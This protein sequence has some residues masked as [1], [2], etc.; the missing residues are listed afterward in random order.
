MEKKNVDFAMAGI[1]HHNH[2]I[3]DRS[4]H[5]ERGFLFS[6]IEELL[7]MWGQSSFRTSQSS[8]FPLRS[9]GIVIIGKWNS[10][11]L[12]YCL[13]LRPAYTFYIIARICTCLP[14]TVVK[15]GKV[16]LCGQKWCVRLNEALER[17]G[18]IVPPLWWTLSRQVIILNQ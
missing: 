14:C 12:R 1:V 5:R 18:L 11:T 16:I 3:K 7:V 2:Q 8:P 17:Y 6:N 9:A 15:K 13:L 4:L 10:S